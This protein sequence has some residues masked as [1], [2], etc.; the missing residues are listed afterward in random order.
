MNII[1]NV[2]PKTEERINELETSGIKIIKNIFLKC[3]LTEIMFDYHKE[4]YDNILQELNITLDRG[5]ES[6]SYRCYRLFLQK[7]M[8]YTENIQL[9]LKQKMRLEIETRKQLAEPEEIK[10]INESIVQAEKFLSDIKCVF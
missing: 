8:E 2:L 5:G 6:P 10:T 1:D 3:V 4:K 9:N 7:E